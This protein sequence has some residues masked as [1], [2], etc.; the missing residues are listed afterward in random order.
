MA[1][2]NILLILACILSLMNTSCRSVLNIQD[3]VPTASFQGVKVQ[4]FP[5]E[6]S[7]E[8]T[9]LKLGLTFAYKNPYKKSLPIPQHSFSFKLNGKD[10]P[11]MPLSKE[12]F[13][14]PAEDSIHITY[15]ATFDLNPRGKLSRYR[16]LG[17][18]NRLE[19]ASSFTVNLVEYAGSLAT[20]FDIPLPED[21]KGSELAKTYLDKKLGSRTLELSHGM[22]F[23]LPALPQ[24]KASSNPMKVE[25]IGQMET[26]DLKLLKDGL[27]PMVNTL[28]ET[29]NS[30]VLS[31][32]F[33]SMMKDSIDVFGIGKVN[34]ASYLMTTILTPFYG[35]EANQK[36]NEFVGKLEPDENVPMLNHLVLTYVDPNS[37]IQTQWEN[38]VESWGDLD[39]M[40]DRIEFPGPRVTGMEVSIPFIFKNTNEFPIEAPLFFADADFN[41][42]TPISFEMGVQGR[43]RR[44]E[45]GEEK[46]LWVKLRLNWNM[47]EASNGVFQ[48]LQ[49]EQFNTRLK[50][51]TQID[52]GYGPMSVKID[53]RNM[54]LQWGN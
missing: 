17:K 6:L 41:S 16:V 29:N 23:R 31:D 42:F 27:S 19:F 33:V 39:A 49:G 7:L 46:E 35:V 48:L 50:G 20:S 52:M 4:Q 8:E 9:D 22:N 1:Y 47:N 37:P 3:V 28:I 44:I 53:L 34:V 54:K 36:W 2:R 5:P 40:P 13:I 38:F 11:G 51:E 18:D 10:L 21:S 26:L 24:I 25:F 43:N 45:A 30:N 12:G 14:L 15:V 32:P